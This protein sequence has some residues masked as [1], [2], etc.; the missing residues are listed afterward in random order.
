VADFSRAALAW[1]ARPASLLGLTTSR[2]LE[3]GGDARGTQPADHAP[4]PLLAEESGS[5]RRPGAFPSR[6]QRAGHW[7]R[8]GAPGGRGRPR[9]RRPSVGAAR[10][11]AAELAGPRGAPAVG[12]G[13]RQPAAGH[14]V[15]L[16]W[17]RGPGSVRLRRGGRGAGA[18]RLGA[19]GGT[20][21]GPGRPGGDATRT[22]AGPPWACIALSCGR[23]SWLCFA[24]RATDEVP[25]RPPAIVGQPRPH[26]VA[27]RQ[28]VGLP[29]VHGLGD[30]S[31]P[32]GART[33]LDG[34]GLSRRRLRHHRRR[35]RGL[36]RVGPRHEWH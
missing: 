28:G 13:G 23:G 3:Q 33:P 9:E 29:D 24:S 10:R 25:L 36:A 16:P 4:R 2:S 14:P 35:W 22:G 34:A 12:T 15:V 5:R 31:P 26:L 1:P 32:S 20:A 6:R 21:D 27:S 18:P 8:G 7:P 19:H 11:G 30:G 17:V